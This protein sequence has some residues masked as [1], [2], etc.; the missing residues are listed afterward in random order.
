VPVEGSETTGFGAVLG[1]AAVLSVGSEF[2][3]EDPPFRDGELRGDA[4]ELELP[5]EGSE[6][7]GFGAVAGALYEALQAI[8]Y[9][10][11]AFE[12]P[13]RSTEV[14]IA[15]VPDPKTSARLPS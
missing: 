12:N 7:T 8:Q 4:L 9:G 2:G 1:E 3:H 5:V 10:D 11:D 14:M 13:I 15:A 6:T